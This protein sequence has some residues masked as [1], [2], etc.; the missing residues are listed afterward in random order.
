M[1]QIRLASLSTA[2]NRANF[3]ALALGGNPIE[4]FENI[5]EQLPL[6]SEHVTQRSPPS[7]TAPH[8]FVFIETTDKLM[9]ITV[10]VHDCSLSHSRIERDGK[11]STAVCCG[12]ATKNA[13]ALFL[14]FRNRLLGGFEAD[15][16]MRPIAKRFLGGSA[17]AT[18][19]HSFFGGE[20]VPIRVDQFHFARHDVRTVLDCF[21]FQVSHG[22][23]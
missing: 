2:S 1:L 17:A 9:N 19:C 14:R 3:A 5:L 11:D 6:R 21:D 23:H 16:R 15:L 22:A 13:Y 12:A 20:F 7:E 10:R 4:S 8:C 18:K